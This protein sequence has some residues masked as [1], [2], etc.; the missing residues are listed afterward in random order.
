MVWNTREKAN[1]QC[2]LAYVDQLLAAQLT[3]AERAN[4]EAE[5]ADICLLP[6]ECYWKCRTNT[7]VYYVYTTES[8]SPVQYIAQSSFPV[9]RLDTPNE[10]ELTYVL[11]Q[12]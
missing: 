7:V 6:R 8:S 1:C 5:A 10:R 12:I 11:D 4:L 3:V 9:Q 2:A